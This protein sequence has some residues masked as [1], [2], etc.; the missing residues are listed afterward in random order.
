MELMVLQGK[1]VWMVRMA[2]MV[3]MEQLEIL[4]F[5]DPLAHKDRQGQR[6]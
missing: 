5:R 1:M 2:S 6:A 4:D 3:R